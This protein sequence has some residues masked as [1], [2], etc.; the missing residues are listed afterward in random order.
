MRVLASPGTKTGTPAHARELHAATLL[1]DGRIVVT[2][3]RSHRGNLLVET[4]EIYEPSSG[5]WTPGPDLLEARPLPGAALLPDGR[6]VIAGGGEVLSTETL[7]TQA[8]DESR[9]PVLASVSGTLAHGGVPVVLTGSGFRGDSEAGGGGNHNGAAVGYALVRL[10]ALD[11][12][13]AEDAV[14]R[15][16]LDRDS[17]TLRIVLIQQE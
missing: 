4:T 1:P 17:V 8:V 7:Q 15:Q 13:T 6:L 16:L 5:A 11:E 14:N 3:G 12:E 10:R 9:R 2:A